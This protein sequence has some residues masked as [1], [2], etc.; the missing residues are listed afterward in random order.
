MI[1]YLVQIE[2][3][4][5]ADD[6]NRRSCLRHVLG[7]NSCLRYCFKNSDFLSVKRA[8]TVA[9]VEHMQ[10]F[11]YETLDVQGKNYTKNVMVY[12]SPC[13]SKFFLK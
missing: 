9:N 10:I 2:Y 1:K 8:I 11:F 5:L 12:I 7:L 13:T 3:T 4:G 6:D